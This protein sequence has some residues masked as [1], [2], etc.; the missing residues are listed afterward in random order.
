MSE[1]KRDSQVDINELLNRYLPMTDNKAE[2]PPPAADGQDRPA[3]QRRRAAVRHTAPEAGGARADSENIP[4]DNAFAAAASEADDDD[5]VIYG[6]GGGEQ[7]KTGECAVGGA[8]EAADTSADGVANE[9]PDASVFAQYGDGGDGESYDDI[10]GE[11]AETPDGAETDED[12]SDE[13]GDL[14]DFEMNILLGLGMDEELESTVG[15]E[16]VSN[17]V[18]KQQTTLDKKVAVNRER[19]EL[20]YEY[21]NKTQ[22]KEIA[23]RYKAAY[24]ISKLK[25]AAAAVLTLVL[26]FYECHGLFGITLSGPL[27]PLTYPVVYIM[28]GLQIA[29]IAAAP[30][31][32]SLYYG[33]KNFFRGRPT[34][35]CVA[36][37]AL[38]FDIIYSV[39][40]SFCDTFGEAGPETFNLPVATAFLMLYVYEWINQRREIMSFGVISSGKKKFALVSLSMADS[41]LEHEA[42]SDLMDESDNANDISVL[43]IEGA[44][45]VGDYFLRTNRY[46]GGRKFIGFVIPA[47]VIVSAAFYFVIDTPVLEAVQWFTGNIWFAFFVGIFFGV[48]FIDLGCSLFAYSYSG[49]GNMYTGLRAAISVALTCLPISVFYMFSHPFYRAVKKADEE[50]CTIVGEGSV[51]EYANAAIVSF[52]DKSVFPSTGVN[53]RGINI[54]GNNRIDRVIYTTASV[55]C[56]LGGPLSDVFDLATRDI[57]HSDDVVVENCLPGLLEVTV[58]GRQVMYGSIDM[59]EEAGVRIPRPLEEHRNDDFGDN[60]SVMYMVENGRFIARML[61]QYLLDADFEFTLKQ[62]D[63]AGMFVGIKTFDPNITEE[64]LGRQVK[65]KKYPVRVIRCK[66]LEDRTL[67]EETTV[68]GLVST[69]S[70][71]TLMPAVTLCERVLHARSI[72]T[73]LVVISLFV[74]LLVAALSVLFSAIELSPLF[75]AIYGLFWVVPMFIASRMIVS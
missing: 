48:F 45:F 64:F 68:S 70:P 66:A 19:A 71:K 40:I 10:A 59:I 73:M 12:D 65:L 17:F 42:F 9:S 74:S 49:S 56:T 55:F 53:V 11:G 7:T 62:L 4:A 20:D 1:E 57:G 8:P 38:I 2:T 27:D 47:I 35:E 69:D 52:D 37:F 6:A 72:N 63:R 23:E 60:V 39:G 3:R 54:F 61:I 58:D 41:H 16:R 14:D 28:I 33:M 22:T 44:D 30:S 25:L 36:A 46:A 34:P 18:K 29:L 50:D 43:K 21:T 5:V 15:T 31:I 26:F 67:V 75:I 24:R 51:E 13:F 32:M